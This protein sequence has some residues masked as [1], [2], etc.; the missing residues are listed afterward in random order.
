MPALFLPL[1]GCESAPEAPPPAPPAVEAASPEPAGAGTVECYNRVVGYTVRYPADWHVNPGEVLPDCSV[2]DPEPIDLPVG[3]EI[4]TDLAIVITR[5]RVP[6][7]TVSAEGPFRDD[8][9]RQPVQV[10][11]RR[12]LQVEGLSTGDGLYDRGLRSYQY[13]IDL[14]GATLVATTFDSGA[15]DFERKRGV[16]DAMMQALTLGAQ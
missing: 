15:L 2:F 3:S 7:D 5:E 6:F 8:L 4:P 1:A 16:L 9:L 11:G 13:F 10:A 14:G 12:A